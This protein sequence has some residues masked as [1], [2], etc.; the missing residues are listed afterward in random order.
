MELLQEVLTMLQPLRV[1]CSSR[2]QLRYGALA[3][4]FYII[5]ALSSANAQERLFSGDYQLAPE[6]SFNGQGFSYSLQH[7]E[8]C[9]THSIFTISFPSPITS[10]VATNNTVPGELYVPTGLPNTRQYPAVLVFHILYGNFELERAICQAL[11]SQGVT[12][13]FF[14][15][16]YYGE[17][18]GLSGGKNNHQKMTSDPQRFMD[19]LSQASA[20]A[21]RC[22]D[23]I[24]SLP[25]ISPKKIGVTGGS[26]GAIMSASVCGF[27][28][29]INRALLLLGGGN[30]RKI[31]MSAKETRQLRTFIERMPEAEREAIFAKLLEVDPLSQAAALQKLNQQGKLKMICAAEDEVVPPE[32][33]QELAEAVGCDINW[34]PGLGHYTVAAAMP[35]ILEDLQRFF[36]AD[37]PASWRA[38]GVI[39]AQN[40]AMRLT[41]SFLQDL[42]ALLNSSPMPGTMQRCQLDFKL[43]IQQESFNGSIDYCR[44]SGGR[45]RLA[46]AIPRLGQAQIG[47]DEFPWLAGANNS[48]FVG[49]VDAQ[50]GRGCGQYVTPR[51]F[52]QWQVGIG[53]LAGAAMA[54]D[55]LKQ[56]CNFNN[57]SA[58][59]GGTTLIISSA[60]DEVPAEVTLSFAPDETPRELRFNAL[61]YAG[62]INIQK[63]QING[64]EE[65]ELFAPPPNAKAKDVRQEDVL[66]MIAALMERILEEAE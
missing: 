21:R 36:S 61:G 18:G 16:P 6:Q 45:Y 20:D 50:A 33:S 9:D 46:G 54:P 51:L 8:S 53:S 34:L 11:A 5:V 3:L 66:R 52:V 19:A 22:I 28:P 27:E 37:R 12:A 48:V 42:L 35:K 13:L 57:S 59:D 26:L 47:Q 58:P 63:W 10:A 24:S 14:K 29:R 55:L 25:F 32:C 41:G 62:T 31:I 4:L 40:N 60:H 23:I 17:R 2:R 49:S 64:P 7:V 30:L 1:C 43:S 39:A 65:A 44:G 56:F 15:L 38:P